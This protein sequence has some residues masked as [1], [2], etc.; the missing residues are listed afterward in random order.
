M[1]KQYYQKQWAHYWIITEIDTILSFHS[2][3][4]VLPTQKPIKQKKRN[5]YLTTNRSEERLQLYVEV[6]ALLSPFSRLASMHWLIFQKKTVWPFC[7]FP[8]MMLR[9]EL[10]QF[11][12]QEWKHIVAVVSTMQRT[13]L[14]KKKNVTDTLISFVCFPTKTTQ[15]FVQEI[16]T[17]M[18]CSAVLVSFYKKLYLLH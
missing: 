12:L 15:D 2:K 6:V 11:P 10:S 14:K 5:Y 1:H 7:F 18:V 3:Y 13:F 16:I 4:S 9:I 8:N 17:L